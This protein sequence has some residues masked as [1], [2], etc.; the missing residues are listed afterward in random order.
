MTLAE[1]LMPQSVRQLIWPSK[2][3]KK[4]ALDIAEGRA[5]DNLLLFGLPGTGKTTTIRI[6]ADHYVAN[7]TTFAQVIH[8]TSH[9]TGVAAVNQLTQTISL[10]GHRV[11]VINELD[12]LSSDAQQRLRTVMDDATDSTRFFFTTNDL[13]A[14]H[15]AIQSRCY[16]A[17]WEFPREA[18]MAF[19]KFA[20]EREA[21]GWS[22]TDLSEF[23]KRSGTDLRQ[24]IR[25]M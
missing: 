12:N 17:K 8:F 3:M 1:K 13:Q 4:K 16:V 14:I 21:L 24:L 10:V 9:Q 19:A 15:P 5:M 22:D 25:Q 20:N 2:A 6:L 23:V 18:M 7:A 11:V